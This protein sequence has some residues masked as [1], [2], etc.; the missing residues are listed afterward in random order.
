MKKTFSHISFEER[1]TIENG[2]KNCIS[3]ACIAKMINKSKST[4]SYEIKKN[5]GRD[6]YS[7]VAAHKRRDKTKSYS[8][9]KTSMIQISFHQ[10]TFEERQKIEYGLKTGCTYGEI[11]V[12][13]NRAKATIEQEV[14]RNDGRNGYNAQKAQERRTEILNRVKLNSGKNKFNKDQHSI[15]ERIKNV[16][17]KLEIIESHLEIILDSREMKND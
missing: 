1:K 12:L 3:F 10:L 16:E 13:L 15:W 4:I 9:A 11:G 14:R 5:G 6:N 8:N 2:V 17:K 7:A